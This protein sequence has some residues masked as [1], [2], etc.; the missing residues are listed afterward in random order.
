MLKLFSRAIAVYT[1][2]KSNQAEIEPMVDAGET[3]VEHVKALIAARE[4]APAPAA[5]KS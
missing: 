3:L 1:F 5:S 2:L 4:A